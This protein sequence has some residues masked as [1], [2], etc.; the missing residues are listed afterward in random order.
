MGEMRRVKPDREAELES[1]RRAF[2]PEAEH[3]RLAWF[4][5]VEAMERTVAELLARAGWSADEA[6]LQH[7]A[8]EA[9]GVIGAA[10]TDRDLVNYLRDSAEEFGPA[11]K[12]SDASLLALAGHIREA[13][14]QPFGSSDRAV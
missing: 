5:H 3:E 14:G 10:G 9:L 11:N 6:W 13:A 12:S 2:S 1:L 8:R 7:C 4:A